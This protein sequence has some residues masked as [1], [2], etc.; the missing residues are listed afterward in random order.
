MNP[1]LP[2][3][4]SISVATMAKMFLP[5][6]VVFRIKLDNVYKMYLHTAEPYVTIK[7]NYKLF[8]LLPQSYEEIINVKTFDKAPCQISFLK[9][10]VGEWIELWP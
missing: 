3:S 4:I 5:H 2:G 10:S 6:R 1:V 9:S 7:W 8:S